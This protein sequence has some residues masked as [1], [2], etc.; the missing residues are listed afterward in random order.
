MNRKMD[1]PVF[2]AQF[3]PR[4]AT[5]E[6]ITNRENEDLNAPEWNWCGVCCARMM[7]LGVRG[8]APSMD[9][10]YRKAFD[11]Y[12]VFR[13]IDG[14]VVGSYHRELARY[15]CDEFE[16]D[17]MPKRGLRPDDLVK[18]VREG[19]CF[20]AS[21][22]AKIRFL[23]EETPMKKVGHLVLIY[24][25][26]ETSEGRWFVLH[27]SA[28][29]A[30]LG[31]QEAVHVPEQRFMDCFSGNGIVVFRGEDKGEDNSEQT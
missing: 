8:D 9:E 29:F 28:G 3:E 22:S 4:E 11:E 27:N 5:E 17:A 13:M 24:D 15:L 26:V 20:I 16:F 21:V 6:R 31:T 18:I 1:T 2:V 30:S 25:V 10:M 7:V 12:G 19:G 23:E 14:E